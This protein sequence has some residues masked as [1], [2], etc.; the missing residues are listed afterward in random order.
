MDDTLIE[1]MDNK[2]H[3][4]K[5][6][7]DHFKDGLLEIDDSFQRKFVWIEKHQIKLIET[8]LIGYPIPEVYI[9]IQNTQPDT[10]DTS[11]SIVDGQ[12]RLSSVKKF[13]DGEFKLSSAALE[14]NDRNYVNKYFSDL[15]EDQKSKIWRFPFSVRIIRNQ[16]VREKIV[17]MFLRLNETSMT[18]NPQELRHAEFDGEFIQTSKEI[19]DHPFWEEYSLFNAYDIRRM[20]D[21]QFMSSILM[22]LRMGIESETTQTNINK[23]YDLYNDEYEEKEEDK[24]LFFQLI[25]Y[26]DEIAEDH[27]PTQSL[28]NRK[29]HL[30]TLFTVLY[31]IHEEFDELRSNHKENYRKFAEYYSDDEKLEEEYSEEEFDLIQEYKELV[32]QGTKSRSKRHRRFEIIESLVLE[33]G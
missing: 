4:T 31:A 30:Y 7:Y 14:N 24:E 12:Q 28:I 26:I 18:L 9:W 2:T 21:V 27:E 10:G 17:K 15:T 11:Y 22:F 1:L 5:W 16:V 3:D 6:F 33:N 19:A 23:L 20:L 25:D 29:T 13:I 32:Q 8:I